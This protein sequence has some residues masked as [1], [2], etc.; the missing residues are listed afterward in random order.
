MLGVTRLYRVRRAGGA[1]EV[2]YRGET[3]P[4]YGGTLAADSL[5]AICDKL[6]LGSICHY[7]ADAPGY[8]TVELNLTTRQARWLNLDAAWPYVPFVAPYRG[9]SAQ[10]LWSAPT[11]V[12]VVR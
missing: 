2:V 10:R 3:F 12:Y 7:D 4:Q 11:G 1:V 6:Y 5:K 8:G 9:A